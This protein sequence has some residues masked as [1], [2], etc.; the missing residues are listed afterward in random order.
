[1]NN[2]EVPLARALPAVR[3]AAARRQ[4]EVYVGG[5]RL[6]FRFSWRTGLTASVITLAT[7]G[8]GLAVAANLTKGPVPISPNGTLEFGKAPSF[9]SVVSGDKVVGYIPRSDIEPVR[10]G[11]PIPNGTSG[12]MTV[13]G[14]DLHTVVGHMYPG[15]GFAALGA[16]P[17]TSCT[18]VTTIGGGI[19]TS[20]ACTGTA[21]SVPDVVGMSTPSAAAKLS[22]LGLSVR[23]VNVASTSVPHGHVVMMSPAPG[24]GLV[25]E[26][27]V[28]IEN[29]A[30]TAS[31]AE[32]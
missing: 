11:T 15:V 3:A 4:L 18:T 27:T 31:N 16:T 28:T 30:N 17:S 9:V 20:T 29:S 21:I 22:G 26:V 12:V 10:P 5:S 2:L 19:S 23:V 32:G 8:G 24:S 1:M 25:N 14:S 6:R 7:V 13:Y